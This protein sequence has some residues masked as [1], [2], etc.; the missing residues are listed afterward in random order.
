LQDELG[1]HFNFRVHDGLTN[2]VTT[3]SGVNWGDLPAWAGVV[4][5]VIFGGL[6]W[7]S[8]KDAKAAEGAAEGYKDDALKAAQ[9]A[10]AAQGLAAK[11]LEKN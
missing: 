2:R 5:T 4:A 1:R 7:K 8:S 10:A 3:L 9:D 11:A 6:A